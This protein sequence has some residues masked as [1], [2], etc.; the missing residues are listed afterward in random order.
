MCIVCTGVDSS[1]KITTCFFSY[2]RTEMYAF[3]YNVIV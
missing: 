2:D 1:Y 3:M